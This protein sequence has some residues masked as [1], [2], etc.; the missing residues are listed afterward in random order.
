MR[1]RNRFS[2][3]V[4]LLMAALPAAASVITAF[5]GA[6]GPGLDSMSFNEVVTPAPGNDDVAGPSPNYVSI[7]QKAFAAVGI[8][9]MVF[10]VEDFGVPSTE[11]MIYE[12]V[13]N[14]TGEDWIGYEIKLGYGIGAD[15]EQAEV[16]G[17]LDL[18]APD[19]NSPIVFDPPYAFTMIGE[20]V[21]NA[22]DGVFTAGAFHTFQFAVDVPNGISEFT[23]RQEPRNEPVAAM[24]SAWSEVKAL[25]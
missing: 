9:D 24:P 6:Y 5:E 23:I 8:I 4:M 17:G 15:F 13:F 18:D 20:T 21:H 11:Y 7:N 22:V 14:G 12:G 25:Y 3:F 2:I 19:Y 10:L 1:N 16:G